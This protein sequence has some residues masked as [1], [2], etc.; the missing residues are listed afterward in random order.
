MKRDV[1]S[2]DGVLAYTLNGKGSRFLIWLD[3][4]QDDW[5]VTDSLIHE[6]V[7]IFQGVCK[8][9]QED[10]PGDEFAAYTT[11]FIATTLLKAYQQEK[12]NAVHEGWKE[13]LQA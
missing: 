5:D 9:I 2:F 1:P 6:A 4:K 8:Y 3:D 7:H 10:E 11:A 12:N 13:G